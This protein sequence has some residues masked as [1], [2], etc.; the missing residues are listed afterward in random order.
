[1]VGWVRD[2]DAVSVELVDRGGHL[3]S[4]FEASYLVGSS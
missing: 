4:T 1:M 3:L 2:E